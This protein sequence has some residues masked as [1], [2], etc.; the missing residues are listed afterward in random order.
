LEAKYPSLKKPTEEVISDTKEVVGNVWKSGSERLSNLPGAGLVGASYNAGKTAV[1]S[2]TDRVKGAYTGTVDT[3]S[4]GYTSG[5]E[6]LS[7]GYNYGKEALASGYN[8]G[9]EALA[10][11][12]TAGKDYVVDGIKSSSSYVSETRAGHLVGR[13][14]GRILITTD[15]VVEYVLPEGDDDEEEEEEEELKECKENDDFG[16]FVLE[17]EQGQI[18]KAR[19]ISRKIRV[20]V[21]R[22]TMFRL[23]SVQE[24][25]QSLLKALKAHTELLKLANAVKD[26]PSQGYHTVEE[27]VQKMKSGE[28]KLVPSGMEDKLQ[29]IKEK[30]GELT[31]HNVLESARNLAGDVIVSAQSLM[32]GAAYLPQS[33]SEGAT[34]AVNHATTILESLRKAELPSDIPKS[35]LTAISGII[36]R[37]MEYANRVGRYISSTLS[38]YLYLGKSKE[39]QTSEESEETVVPGG[40]SVP[41]QDNTNTDSPLSERPITNDDVDYLLSSEES[42]GDSEEG[43]DDEGDH[44]AFKDTKATPDEEYDTL[45]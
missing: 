34:R 25:Y 37:Q 18:E 21:Y 23:H 5:K 26:F 29:W 32:K 8:S 38:S 35:T 15:S 41:S 22:R 13:G 7:S 11:G 19:T 3:V 36:E 27:Y 45:D 9:K 39:S 17:E 43:S 20:R 31:F 14:V 40:T 33:L 42:D 4:S 24:R 16:S 30:S 12:Y 2:T 6:R 1:V 10:S 28:M 44:A